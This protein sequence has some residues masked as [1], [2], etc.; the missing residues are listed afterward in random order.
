MANRKTDTK[1]IILLNIT[2][3][4]AEAAGVFPT[5]GLLALPKFTAYSK[6]ALPVTAD[7]QKTWCKNGRPEFANERTSP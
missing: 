2:K 1:Y 4:L 3:V 7:T 5:A 6:I